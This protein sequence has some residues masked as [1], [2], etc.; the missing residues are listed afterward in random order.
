[1]E[2]G[3][4]LRQL[5]LE[6]YEQAFCDNAID[7]EVLPELTDADLEQLGLLL[8]HR[9]KLQKATAELRAG[10]PGA[11]ASLA[12]GAVASPPALEAERRQLTVLFRDLVG[13]TELSARLD[14]EDMREVIRAY[15]NAV[16]GEITRF[17]GHVAKFM[18]DGVLAYFGWPRAHEDGPEHAVRA[19]LAITEVVS[20]LR[21]PAGE[22]LA[23]RIGIATGLVVVGD[24]IGHGASQEQAVVGET[25]NL[26]ARLQAL[27]EPGQVVIAPATRRLLGSGFDLADLGPQRLKGI[28]Q[29]VAVF[30]VRG[31]R[32][33]ADRFEARS[34]RTL[35]PMVG[36]D[37][38]LAL[39]LKRWARA[40]AGEGQGVLLT[41]EP[42]IGK[43]RIR[44]A[45]LDAVADEPHAR[46]SY[47]C[48]PYHGDSAL[49]PVIQQLHHA[50]G[51]EK[52]DPTEGRLDKL[53][54]L[55]EQAGGRAVAPLI[56]DLIGLDGVA[57]YGELGLTPQVQRARTLDALVGLLLGLAAGQ[58]VLA[59]VED[60]H[61]IDPTTLEMIER[62][63]ACIADA[64]VLLLV[65]SRPERQPELAD[66]PHIAR[67]V[68]NRLGRVEAEAIL[69]R[70]G[71]ERLPAA[72]IDA[73]IGRTDGVPLFV[74]E[75]TKA[76]VETGETS[77]PASLHD[78][79]MARLDR[80]PE[81]KGIAQIAACIGR[82]VDFRLLAAVA[83]RP[84]PELASALDRLAAAELI[85]RRRTP[86]RT[87]WNFKHALVQD[88]AYQSLLRSRRQQL[89]ARI[90]EVLEQRFP[91]TVA[92]EPELL[93]H[94][95]TGAGLAA[96]AIPHWLQAGL[97]AIQ[98]SAHAEAS[99][100]LARG[101]ELLEA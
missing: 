97:R 68:L 89:H 42:G 75:L 94:H 16:A 25:P 15:Q 48:S 29:P 3:D 57:R 52:D 41:G 71:G 90:A 1:L 7:L 50:A 31:E 64:R 95:Y 98:R 55:L 53:E 18:G 37:R 10:A 73:I 32:A 30:A 14:P 81:V 56:A 78:S 77:V 28:A 63:L 92:T 20:H 86:S 49:W 12:E 11:P 2:I 24:L 54:A 101:L 9:R 80:I 87:T 43:S 40:R 35:L 27:G 36:R 58:P 82:E 100:H 59:V 70:L 21:S 22:P 26:A 39:L 13:S 5:G 76:V 44:R 88:A 60:A 91:E 83:A 72:T 84:E 85:I 23:A 47:Q 4:W 67:L 96:Q 69:A 45:L 66:H 33:I 74:E 93:A 17:E 61:W 99:A 34:G 38:E 62:C 19:A 65:T 8:G 51:L 6:R 79:L 46:I